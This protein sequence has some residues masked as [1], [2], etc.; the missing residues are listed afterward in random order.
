[1][2]KDFLL[3]MIFY[4]DLNDSTQS[5]I[6][7]ERLSRSARPRPQMS[8]LNEEKFQRSRSDIR[9][10][11]IHSEKKTDESARRSA[12]IITVKQDKPK[13]KIHS[14]KS[15]T[16]NIRVEKIQREDIPKST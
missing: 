5:K 4:L 15:T 13:E 6:S 3:L 14:A 2:N 12:L 1:M 9:V 16:S 11:R 8:S 7:V 10:E